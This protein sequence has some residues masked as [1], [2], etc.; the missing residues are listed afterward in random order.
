MPGGRWAVCQNQPVPCLCGAILPRSTSPSAEQARFLRP[1]LPGQG[2]ARNS[3]FEPPGTSGV[4]QW[5]WGSR[6]LTSTQPA[7]GFTTAGA[8]L[9]PGPTYESTATRQPPAQPPRGDAQAWVVILTSL[10]DVAGAPGHRAYAASKAAALQL[11]T[12]ARTPYRRLGAPP[13]IAALRPSYPA[14]PARSAVTTPRPRPAGWP[15]E[16]PHRRQVDLT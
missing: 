16:A 6:C 13:D 12:C 15:I 4:R 3:I 9:L 11:T 10:H 8:R 1:R 7:S 14:V 2:A 5:G